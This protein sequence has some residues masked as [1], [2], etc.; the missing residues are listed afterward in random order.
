ME[1]IVH[2]QRL[3]IVRKA[4]TWD[5]MNRILVFARISQFPILLANI[6]SKPLV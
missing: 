1:A 3:R 6:C 2:V 5:V 4:K